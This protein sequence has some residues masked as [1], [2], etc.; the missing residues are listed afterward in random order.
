MPKFC[1]SCLFAAIVVFIIASVFLWFFPLFG[2]QAWVIDKIDDI[3]YGPDRQELTA[4]N[5]SNGSN[6][7]GDSDD[8]TVGANDDTGGADLTPPSDYNPPDLTRVDSEPREGN[9]VIA[10]E[11]P[12]TSSLFNA[13][14]I[15]QE[16]KRAVVIQLDTIKVLDDQDFFSNGE[17]QVVTAVKSGSTVQKTASPYVNWYEADGGDTVKIAKPI[18]VL[19]EDQLGDNIT[20][21]I[22]AM[23]NDSLPAT[24]RGVLDLGFDINAYVA[25]ISAAGTLDDAIN[26]AENKKD[27]FLDWIGGSELIGNHTNLLLKK[28]NYGFKSENDFRTISK[29]SGNMEVTYRMYHVAI[30]QKFLKV[31]VTLQS[32]RGGETGDDVVSGAGDLYIWNYVGDGFAENGDATGQ[33]VRV[34]QDGLHDV[35]DGESWTINKTIYSGITRSP[36]LYLESGVWDADDTSNDDTVTILRKIV[37]LWGIDGPRQFAVMRSTSRELGLDADGE[38]SIV[39]KVTPQD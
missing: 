34:N 1:L 30:P 13:L 37:P 7:S 25:G 26:Y 10:T 17:L 3:R 21:L 5:G 20:I 19:P 39:V 15:T 18:F 29:K 9:D 11:L 4:P 35:A 36:V 14:P 6:G 28:D 33:A 31:E 38:V 2:V 32:F 23:D 12:A 27:T 8:D 22:T 16:E 24:A